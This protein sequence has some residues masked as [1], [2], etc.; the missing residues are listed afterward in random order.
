M[1]LQRL[2]IKRRVI[3]IFGILMIFPIMT[4][5]ISL[6]FM[7]Q[8]QRTSLM[9][10]RSA[11]LYLQSS[12]EY[13]NRNILEDFSE[14]FDRKITALSNRGFAIIIFFTAGFI[15]VTILSGFIFLQNLELKASLLQHQTDF[16]PEEIAR[17][18]EKLAGRIRQKKRDKSRTL[19]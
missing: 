8:L 15:I 13:P 18:L 7:K 4:S 1:N 5:I 6:S 14:K 12:S 3:V 19:H 9:E 16:T 11:V 17:T 10:F 2:N